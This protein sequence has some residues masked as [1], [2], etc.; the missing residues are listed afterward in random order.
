MSLRSMVVQPHLREQARLERR[1]A[2]GRVISAF[3]ADPDEPQDRAPRAR[4]GPVD[5]GAAQ[6][7]LHG[8][9]GQLPPPES[10]EQAVGLP[11]TLLSVSERERWQVSLGTLQEAFGD[12]PRQRIEGQLLADLGGG[13]GRPRLASLALLR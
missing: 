8:L 7:R 1:S 10:L 9:R 3:Q 4:R 11:D 6:R 5:L 13:G 2:S 12:S